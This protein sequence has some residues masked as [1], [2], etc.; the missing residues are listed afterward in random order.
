[1]TRQME[2]PWLEIPIPVYPPHGPGDYNP[3]TK[4]NDSDLIDPPDEEKRVI[5]IDLQEKIMRV[6]VPDKE[7]NV[8]SEV[9]QD[10]YMLKKAI[11]YDSGTPDSRM[12]S[13]DSIRDKLKSLLKE[14]KQSSQ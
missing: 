12:A 4:E 3:K 14:K 13:V 11:D 7:E 6:Y 1:M 2:R 9:L 5:V 10:L 8:I